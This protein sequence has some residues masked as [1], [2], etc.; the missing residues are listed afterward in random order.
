MEPF[1]LETHWEPL[2]QE[3][4]IAGISEFDAHVTYLEKLT[5]S[6]TFLKPVDSRIS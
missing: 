4:S 2:Q 5:E 1:A 6:E 3:R